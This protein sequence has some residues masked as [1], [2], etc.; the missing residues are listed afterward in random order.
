MFRIVVLGICE[1]LGQITPLV[2]F[3]LFLKA[4]DKFYLI[5]KINAFL[6]FLKIM[7]FAIHMDTDIKHNCMKALL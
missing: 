7:W 2:F 6:P 1:E 3:F 5:N 4:K